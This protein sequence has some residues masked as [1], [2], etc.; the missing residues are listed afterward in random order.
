MLPKFKVIYTMSLITI[1]NIL[2]AP[3]QGKNLQSDIW[4]NKQIF[5]ASQRYLLSAASGKGKSTLLHILYGLRQDYTGSAFLDGVDIR[6]LS[7]DSWANIRQSMFSIVFQDLRLFPQL[8]AWENITLKN[9]LTQHCTEDQLKDMVIQLGMIDFLNQSAATLSY[10]QRQRIA[11]VRA[12]AQPFKV[13]LLDEPFSHLDDN[14]ISAAVKLIELQC[15]H[16]NASY[17]IV[18]LGEDYGFHWDK[19]LLL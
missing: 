2:P 15:S 4:Q 12:M 13:L 19:K 11:I 9:N 5:E 18:T 14:N 6:S 1:E 17:I 7:P 10:G 16:Q 8:T 3:L